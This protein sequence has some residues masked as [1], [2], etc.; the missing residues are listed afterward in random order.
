VL[1]AEQR[2]AWVWDHGPWLYWALF[3]QEVW[4]WVMRDGIQPRSV[5]GQSG[6]TSAM[7]SRPGHI[8][9]M[10][11]PTPLARRAAG[12]VNEPQVRVDIRRLKLCLF[13]TDEDRVGAQRPLAQHRQ[14]VKNLSGWS[15]L[16]DR[17]P[18][19][20]TGEWMNQNTD[21]V[22]RADWVWHSMTEL[23]VAYNGGVG[24]DLLELLPLYV[25]DDWRPAQ[26]G[27]EYVKQPLGHPAQ[28]YIGP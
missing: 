15:D 8:Y 2:D 28:G 14:T 24:R 23:T 6:M 7:E 5:T 25:H 18:G 22:D 21:V 16:T 19:V 13:A 11:E 12:V 10:T 26:P 17:A 20:S 9:F 1:T 27:E 3:S 4:P